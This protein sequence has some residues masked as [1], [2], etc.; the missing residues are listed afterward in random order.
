MAAS[1]D[2]LSLVLGLGGGLALF[3]YGMDQMAGALRAVGGQRMKAI[4]AALSDNR[5]VGVITGTVVTAVIQS[6]SVTTVMLVGFVSASL[7]TLPQAL[8]VILGAGI[9]TTITAQLVAFK[10][11]KYALGVVALGFLVAVG[12]RRSAVKQYGLAL[13]GLGLLF[14]GMHLMSDAMYPLRDFPPFVSA[15]GAMSHPVAGG[16]AGAAFTALVQSSSATMGVV[17]VLALQGAIDLEAGIALALGANI[18]T[19]ITAA[20]AAIGKPT[21]AVRV[22]VAHVLFKVLGVLMILPALPWFADVVRELS[23]GE[24]VARQVANAHTLFNVAVAFGFLPFIG[25]MAKVLGRIVPSRRGGREEALVAARALDPILLD[26]P[27]LALEAARREVAL[28]GGRVYR[29]LD[30]SLPAVLT[31]SEAALAAVE[32]ADEQVDALHERNAAFLAALSRRDL[33]PE[34]SAV[35]MSLLTAGNELESLGDVI[36][37]DLVALG[38]RRLR[39]GIVVSDASTE[40]LKGLHSQLLQVTRE[41]VRALATNDVAAAAF[42]VDAKP[43]VREARHDAERHQLARLAASA[44][45]R[46]SAYALEVDV[47]DR[48]DRAY[49]HVRRIAKSVA[50]GQKGG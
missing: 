40:V 48:F 5:F 20:L 36:E 15:M 3:L 45:G 22:A 46:G 27:G 8:G 38:R 31:G 17:I 12:G 50:K 19:C 30:E 49:R 42:A 34:Q 24:D 32:A 41:A 14:H 1:V 2:W 7:M 33:T 13:L 18:G 47:I 26:T 16:L 21:E 35:M 10:I 29:M 4:L 44:G 9:G 11:T 37:T 23:Q 6:S 43:A 25:P 28:I 39:D